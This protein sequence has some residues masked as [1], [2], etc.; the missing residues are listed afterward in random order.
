MTY[1]LFNTPRSYFR[2]TDQFI[3]TIHYS[4]PPN[5]SP[6]SFSISFYLYKP[7]TKP[8]FY[9]EWLKNKTLYSVYHY[10]KCLYLFL[11]H[12]VNSHRHFV[13][14][15][16]P[17]QTPYV[18]LYCPSVYTWTSSL[19]SVCVDDACTS[20][21]PIQDLKTLVRHVTHT[22]CLVVIE[23]KPLVTRYLS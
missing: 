6:T 12:F 20:A 2:V 1:L 11:S 17:I 5:L 14:Q 22:G 8:P 9:I 21:R 18:H 10:V 13:S 19:L 16:K 23:Y 15:D 7:S 3:M 4:V